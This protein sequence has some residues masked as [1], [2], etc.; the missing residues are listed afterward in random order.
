MF[1]VLFFCTALVYAQSN[2]YY[3]C[4]CKQ[5]N[6]SNLSSLGVTLNTCCALRQSNYDV[7]PYFTGSGTTVGSQSGANVICGTAGTPCGACPAGQFRNKFNTQEDAA[8]AH[9]TCCS[10]CTVSNTWVN[11]TCPYS[12]YNQQQLLSGQTGT[13]CYATQSVL[14]GGASEV[15]AQIDSWDNR[16]VTCSGSSNSNCCSNAGDGYCPVGASTSHWYNIV[17]SQALS[18]SA[19]LSI[20]QSAQSS[21]TM[22]SDGYAGC[23]YTCAGCN[24]QCPGNGVENYRIKCSF[25][26]QYQTMTCNGW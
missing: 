17:R 1:A 6:G 25:Q 22:T 23:Y 19:A 15:G 21:G 16:S 5:W 26:A 9:Y 12:T 2:D 7:G 14:T 18:S 13:Y 24:R 3:A 10:P 8:A 4:R 11:G 20:C